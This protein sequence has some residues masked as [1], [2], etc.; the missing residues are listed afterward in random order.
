[1]LSWVEIWTGGN[2]NLVSGVKILPEFFIDSSV[3]SSL[4]SYFFD[5]KVISFWLK[6][7][8]GYSHINIKLYKKIIFWT[9]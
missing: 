4:V 2:I 3:L 9:I 1:M 6:N 5:I 7:L 8:Q